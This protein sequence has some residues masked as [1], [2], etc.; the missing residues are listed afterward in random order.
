MRKFASWAGI[1]LVIT[2]LLLPLIVIIPLSL[3]PTSFLS[4][5][6]R[7]LS[8]RHYVA[9]FTDPKWIGSGVDSIIV[10]TLTAISCT[11]L[12]V[13]MASGLWLMNSRWTPVYV[14]IALVPIVA[15]QVV[16]AMIIYYLEARLG[17]LDSYAG[18]V[19]G[20]C[21]VA[22]PYAVITMLVAFARLSRSLERASRSLG[23]STSITL[24]HILLPNVRSGIFGA[25]F[26]SFVISWDEV[27]VTLFIS[28]LN[29]MT[30]PKRIW[31]GLRFDINPVI[32]SVSVIMIIVTI[33]ALIAYAKR[34]T[35]R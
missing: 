8:L 31:D 26:L 10:A 23:A 35:E 15:P 19:V 27:A 20:H 14:T 21:I 2:F 33:I 12:S 6:S 32:A 5:P 28:G 1:L 22:L 13:A 4:F 11:L 9:L 3:T 18:L 30:L 24:W 17:I 7:A 25:A 16:S 29:V 34:S